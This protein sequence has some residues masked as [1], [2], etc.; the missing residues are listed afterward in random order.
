M[1][2]R[3]MAEAIVLEFYKSNG[4]QYRYAIQSTRLSPRGDYWV[5]SCNTAEYVLEGLDEY[6]LVGGGPTLVDVQSGEVTQMSSG[7]TWMQYL[8]DKYDVEAAGGQ[9]YVLHPLFDKQDKHSVVIL[10]QQLG[11][12]YQETL[13]LLRPH[14]EWWLTGP[15]SKLKMCQAR[16]EERQI[17][18]TIDLASGPVNATQIDA[19]WPNASWWP[20][21]QKELRQLTL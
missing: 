18:T 4:K 6:C 7:E 9:S 16:L 8:Q 17:Q 14:R 11:L 15:L 1:I 2:S 5:V 13:S 19:W 10:R 21:L 20:A 12:S 3:E